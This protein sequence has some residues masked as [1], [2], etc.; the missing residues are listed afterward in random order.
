MKLTSRD[1][2]FSIGLISAVAAVLILLAAVQYRW[3]RQINEANE[4][5]VGTSLQ[6]LMM[7]WQ[8]DF[9][10]EFSGVCVALQVGPDAGARDDWE[11]Y[12]QRYV[13][14]HHSAAHPDLVKNVLLW[15]T[16]DGK[17]PRLLQLDLDQKKPT[18]FQSTSEL[19]PLLER[20]QASSSTLPRA[21]RAWHLG[22]EPS[23]G[24]ENSS[25]ASMARN[26]PLTGWQFAEEIPA[27][28][29]PIVHHPVPGDQPGKRKNAVDWIVIV[30][31]REAIQ[32]QIFPEL[33]RRYFGIFEAADYKVAVVEGG[34][35]PRVL[36]ASD[37]FF[38][39]QKVER[40]DAIME[41]FG[42]PPQSTEGHLWQTVKNGI[43]GNDWRKFSGPVWFPIIRYSGEEGGW[44]LILQHRQGSLEDI[45]AAG[46]R[47][48][49]ALSF[50]VILLLAASMALV[51]IASYRVHKLAQ[52]QMDFIA[53]ISHELRTP[54]AVISS[55]AANLTDG[56]VENQQQ[57][58][59]YGTAI[60]NQSRQ[61][62]DLVDQILSFAA[63][64]DRNR[65]MVQPIEV[66]RLI[67]AALD[68]IGDLIERT[69]FQLERHIA[70]DLPRVS[71][72]LTALSQCLQN[73]I[74][75]AV[76]Y[77]GEPRW[78]GV[79]AEVAEDTSGEREVQI[80]IEDRGLGIAESEIDQIFEPF[81]RSPAIRDLQIHGTG[82]GLPLARRIVEAMGGK[83][84]AH[85]KLG[86]GSRFVVHLPIAH[87]AERET[88][89]PVPVDTAGSR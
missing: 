17:D 37:A 66:D 57:L 35:S 40:A 65:F 33:A 1:R 78:I 74:T 86:K 52:L 60:R 54:L 84:T 63:T 47:R 83:L 21:L 23:K 19:K 44:K 73:L 31:D 67:E 56:V 87:E 18:A 36:Y 26:D 62:T 16:S 28:V 43:G 48:N 9:F 79:R 11:D 81:Y 10:R 45:L 77:G 22:D 13:E 76:K 20:L 7:D 75:N 72:D 25:L 68:N 51:I 30:L 50:G 49:L 85:S 82:L 15:E 8:L 41:I 42:P 58:A 53:T 61:L 38:G 71:G 69:G 64:Q 80:S 12:R 32:Q 59:R 88:L 2:I 14:W 24:T 5:R 27:V 70:A 55:A 34:V 6:S 39:E 29:H 46:R 3:S 89:P 4:T